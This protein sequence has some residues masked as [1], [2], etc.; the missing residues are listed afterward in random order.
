MRSRL[1][2]QTHFL[3]ALFFPVYAQAIDIPTGCKLDS[4]PQ[5]LSE[6]EEHHA[7]HPELSETI[8]IGPTELSTAIE[9][10]AGIGTYVDVAVVFERTIRIIIKASLV[11]GI[12]RIDCGG[13]PFLL[14]ELWTTPA[15]AKTYQENKEQ[16][17]TTFSVM[18]CGVFTPAEAR[19][20]RGKKEGA[21]KPEKPGQ[22]SMTVTID[23][24]PYT[25][26]N[27]KL[28]ATQNERE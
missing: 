11:A 21:V 7:Q 13:K 18:L 27:G 10:Y 1:I 6:Q 24:K 5:I 9:G 16:P 2:L 26:E 19:D 14:F 3:L 23:G 25:L 20:Y 28:K 4:S 12:Y 22:P 15:E 17:G 8:I